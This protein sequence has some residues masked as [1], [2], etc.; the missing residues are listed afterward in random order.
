MS[1]VKNGQK[2]A[3]QSGETVRATHLSSV[4]KS[5][6]GRFGT[7]GASRLYFVAVDLLFHMH[8]NFCKITV[9]FLTFG[10][11]WRFVLR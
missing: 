4:N 8:M 3:P 9:D 2:Q 5:F 6:L 1:L 7:W 11:A 10:L